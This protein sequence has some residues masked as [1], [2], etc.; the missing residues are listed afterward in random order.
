MNCK[1]NA[2]SEHADHLSSDEEATGET[3]D[4]EDDD[5]DL[6]LEEE[7]LSDENEEEH[8]PDIDGIGDP[9]DDEQLE[10]DGHFSDETKNVS[11]EQDTHVCFSGEE[12]DDLDLDDD[13]DSIVQ[14]TA[15]EN[16]SNVYSTRE[17]QKTV[18]K[19]H[20]L[21]K[22]NPRVKD[23]CEGDNSH[24]VSDHV[25]REGEKPD[26]SSDLVMREKV[27]PKIKDATNVY[28]M[29]KGED[30]VTNSHVGVKENPCMSS[31]LDTRGGDITLLKSDLGTCAGDTPCLRS[32]NIV[33][34]TREGENTDLNSH[35]GV[36]EKTHLL[37][38]Q[39]MC[40]GENTCVVADHHTREGENR[41]VNKKSIEEEK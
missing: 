30:I 29:R 40:K 22:E 41:E 21:E 4:E 7:S 32:D 34:S 23:T 26:S 15:F 17:G 36:K 3:S 10:S 28:S 9:Q 38:H 19:S 6:D 1:S 18:S 37:P 14:D 11:S 39:D 16:Y 2:D 24:S 8:L 12:D 31:K 5:F 13:D 33:Y 20:I 35:V 25:M 27:N